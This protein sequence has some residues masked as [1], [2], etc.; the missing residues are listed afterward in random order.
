MN[1][2]L[3]ATALESRVGLR[4]GVVPVAAALGAVWTLVLLAVP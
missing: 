2:L 3:A 4:Y 1:R